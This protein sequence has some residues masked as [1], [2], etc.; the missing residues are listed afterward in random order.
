MRQGLNYS[1]LS[2][3]NDETPIIDGT[4]CSPPNT[5]H[6]HLSRV[7]NGQ[8]CPLGDGQRELRVTAPAQHFVN[9]RQMHFFA[10]NFAAG[11]LLQRNVPSFAEL[12]QLPIKLDTSP[13]VNY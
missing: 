11:E 10:T 1:L 3:Q 12:E 2:A 4:V 13:F 9:F 8:R 6:V 5:A 7:D